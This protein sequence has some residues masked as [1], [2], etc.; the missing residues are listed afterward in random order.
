MK[1]GH[2]CRMCMLSLQQC[3]NP[4]V[5]IIRLLCRD[6]C[7]M[8]YVRRTHLVFEASQQSASKASG[9]G[10]IF[11]THSPTHSPTYSPLQ[12]EQVCGSLLLERLR[13]WRAF[14][15]VACAQ[16][17]H[18][19]AVGWRAHWTRGAGGVLHL[20]AHIS[21]NHAYSLSFTPS[22]SACHLWW[23]R[24]CFFLDAA[25][26]DR[27]S[28]IESRYDYLLEEA[29]L[30][31]E[32]EKKVRK[33][34]AMAAQAR[35]PASISPPARAPLAGGDRAPFCARSISRL[36]PL[37]LKLHVCSVIP[38]PWNPTHLLH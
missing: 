35:P 16:T 32:A 18:D 31:A 2:R 15:T 11:P 29:D 3:W 33:Q 23:S 30:G 24:L 6:F 8:V 9:Q 37:E 10:G 7:A 14:C 26:V 25:V 12:D 5:Q 36:S 13:D 17:Q 21:H 34:L 22:G 27:F 28:Q 4:R 1:T 19:R 20:H 38:T